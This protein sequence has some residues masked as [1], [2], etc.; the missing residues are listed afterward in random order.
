MNGSYPTPSGPSTPVCPHHSFSS[1]FFEG[2]LLFFHHRDGTQTRQ[3]NIQ[4]RRD[5]PHLQAFEWMDWCIIP[6][7]AGASLLFQ[8]SEDH[9]HIRQEFFPPFGRGGSFLHY[10]TE[11]ILCDP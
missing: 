3:G 9:I 11:G 7:S 4:Q 5:I 6:F 10:A 2:C 8:L 1:M